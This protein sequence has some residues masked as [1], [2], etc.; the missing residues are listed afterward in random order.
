MALKAL[1]LDKDREIF[2]LLG[3]IFNVTGHKLLIAA[4][5]DMF[6][7]LV[8]STEV[9]IVM[10]NHSD[11]KAWLSSELNFIRKPFNPLEL[12]N[13]LSYLH[14]L[15]PEDAHQLDFVNT[16]VKLTNLKESRIVEVSDGTTC[17]V[18]IYEGAVLGIDCTLEELRGI[19][20]SE[21]RLVKVRDYENLELEQRF[22]DSRDLIKTLI[23][24]AKPVQVVISEG[25]R[26]VREF[27]PVEEI[28][29]NLYRVS[30]FASV[31]VLLKNA[32]LRI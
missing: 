29:E 22:R 13:K 16:I 9:D 5:E 27:R 14:K 31:P 32:Y 3:D 21:K 15:G 25:E 17:N 12:L 6:A 18:L 7:E 8:G 30:K 11:I 28:E 23:E 1:L 10:I 20:E 19:L 24:K 4:N 2:P 26:V